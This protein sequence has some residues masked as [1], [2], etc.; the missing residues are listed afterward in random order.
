MALPE[1]VAKLV[2]SRLAP[3]CE[4]RV[5]EH[6]RD[7]IKLLYTVRGNNVTIFE[8]RP[9]WADPSEWQNARIAQLRFDINRNTWSLFCVDRNQRWQR[10]RALPPSRSI[11]DLVQEIDEDPTGIFWG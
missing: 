1:L 8:S 11:D 4:T 6:A 2:H 5:P 3:F 7:Q 9:L 10:Y